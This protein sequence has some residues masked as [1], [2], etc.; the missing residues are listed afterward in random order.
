[1][2][3]HR[4]F[5]KSQQLTRQFLEIY[6][7]PCSSWQYE[8]LAMS[9][10]AVVRYWTL[11]P[12]LAVLPRNDRHLHPT[13]SVQIYKSQNKNLQHSYIYQQAQLIIIL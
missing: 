2:I 5:T 9:K 3:G 8:A 7:S 1:M 12:P 10:S 4:V 13:Q 11:H 6:H